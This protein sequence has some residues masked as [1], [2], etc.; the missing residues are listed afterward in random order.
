MI[1][2][3]AALGVRLRLELDA[4]SAMIRGFVPFPPLGGIAVHV[5]GCWAH[6]ACKVTIISAANAIAPK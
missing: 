5:A 2:A 3:A 4:S 6:F 1:S